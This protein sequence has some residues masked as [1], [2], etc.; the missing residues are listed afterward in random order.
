MTFYINV[1][2]QINIPDVNFK[3]ELLLLYDK[4]KNSQIELQEID[5]LSYLS[6]DNRNIQDLT[7]I[8]HFKSINYFSCNYNKIVLLDVS[9]LSKLVTLYVTSNKL[10]SLKLPSSIRLV[11][12]DINELPDI[13]VSNLTNL[14]VLRV[15]INKLNVLDISKNI[16]L[17]ELACHTNLLTTIDLSK[18][19]KI[20]DMEIYNNDIENIDLTKGIFD[21]LLQVIPN[22]TLKLVCIRSDQNVNV[23]KFIN[24]GVNFSTTCATAVDKHDYNNLKFSIAPNPLKDRFVINY[25]A[26]QD[27]EAKIIALDGSILYKSILGSG[28]VHNLSFPE[29]LPSG[30]YIIHCGAYKQLIM[31]SY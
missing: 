26:D 13:N 10:T 22:S 8:E 5:T 4:N 12:A 6:V 30:L 3:K 31:K 14:K 17:E 11:H 21:G 20:T 7:G 19:T 1:F 28:T 23:Y 24:P 16:L 27:T 18:N 15:A 25:S 2:A 29:H 9:T